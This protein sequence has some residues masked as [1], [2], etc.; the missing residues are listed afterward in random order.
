MASPLEELMFGP[1]GYAPT[2]TNED[3]EAKQKAEMAHLSLLSTLAPSGIPWREW[4]RSRNIEDHR[5]NPAPSGGDSGARM[6]LDGTIIEAD[7]RAWK[8]TR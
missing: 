1:S 5:N 2:T 8:P 6:L 7:G 4:R 3:W